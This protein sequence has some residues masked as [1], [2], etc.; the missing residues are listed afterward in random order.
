MKTLKNILILFGLIAILTTP[1]FAKPKNWND[2]NPS[3]QH[4]QDLTI[5]AREVR[6]NDTSLEKADTQAD[7][8]RVKEIKKEYYEKYNLFQEENQKKIPD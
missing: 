7:T 8:K 2:T 5:K 3:V 1:S 6:A 4:L